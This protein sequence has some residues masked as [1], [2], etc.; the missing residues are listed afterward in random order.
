MTTTT[1]AFT[2]TDLTWRPWLEPLEPIMNLSAER[3]LLAENSPLAEGSL[4]PCRLVP[5]AA[6][7]HPR[8]L[9]FSA[10]LD[11]PTGLPRAER[12]LVGVVV[13]Y[14]NGC[15]YSAA[16]HGRRYGQLTQTADLIERLFAE[17]IAIDLAPRTRA[18]VDY[19]VKLTQMPDRLMRSDLALLYAA[20]LSPVEILDLTHTV[21]LF[22]WINR[23]FQTLGEPLTTRGESLGLL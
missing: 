1:P 15:V 9:L 10:I 17:G 3:L 12:E 16:V 23:L 11:D 13:S 8:T 18:I 4:S 6:G 22:A 5:E 20:G 2:L 19:A 7:W 14:I 21:A